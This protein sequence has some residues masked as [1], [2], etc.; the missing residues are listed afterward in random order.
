MNV[1][2]KEPGILNSSCTAVVVSAEVELSEVWLDWY[3]VLA[4]DA[5]VMVNTVVVDPEDGLNE[6]ELWDEAL[7]ADVLEDGL[8][9]EE[10]WDEALDAD[11]LE[12]ID[13]V[14][15]V[16]EVSLDEDVLSDDCF[17]VPVLERDE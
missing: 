4:I 14:K 6:E 9:E 17:D 7:E 3:V 13:P 8:N 16:L 10:L 15:V 5:L 12:G 2:M 1:A 11:V